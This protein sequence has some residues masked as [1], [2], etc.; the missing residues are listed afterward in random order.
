MAPESQRINRRTGL[1]ASYEGSHLIRT[2]ENKR[3]HNIAPQFICRRTRLYS[4]KLKQPGSEA[5]TLET[6][7]DALRRRK[8]TSCNH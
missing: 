3:L 8:Q 2:I 6:F 5:G 1:Y 4:G 7:T